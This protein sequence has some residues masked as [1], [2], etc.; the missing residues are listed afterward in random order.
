MIRVISILTV[1]TLGL[2]ALVS[3]GYGRL[4]DW[5]KST[6]IALMPPETAMNRPVPVS[7]STA[8]TEQKDYQIIIKRNIFSAAL[9]DKP[10]VK[11]DPVIDT[12]S[13]GPTTLPLSLLGTIAGG[14]QEAR[15]IIQNT[16]TKA[17]DMYQIGDAVENGTVT[18]IE[19]GKVVLRVRGRNEV[20]LIEVDKKPS[21]PANA[22]SSSIGFP[23]NTQPTM[24]DGLPP[25]ETT[26]RKVRIQPRRRLPA[27]TR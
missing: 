25:P 27:K 18:A 1:I 20:L 22:P 23:A 10:I 9:D 16:K 3:V 26:T 17:Q 11:K 13:L 8:A 7:A 24:M 6:T 14:K 5:L 2:Y 19:R 12:D 15:A 4:E 21:A